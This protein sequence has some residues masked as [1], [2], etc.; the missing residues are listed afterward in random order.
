MKNSKAMI[1]VIILTAVIL[2]L[3]VFIAK[4]ISTIPDK[5]GE[6]INVGK[7]V[8]G[9]TDFPYTVTYDGKTVKVTDG[10]GNTVY[11]FEL[12]GFSLPKEERKKLSDGISLKNM[13][14][15]WSLIESYTS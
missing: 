1:A 2:V 10:E 12:S 15:V 5:I 14:D 13:E 7:T 9:A 11:S 4:S 8:S 6:A 3:T